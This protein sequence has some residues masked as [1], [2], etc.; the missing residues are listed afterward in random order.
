MTEPKQSAHSR[1]ED[2][3]I[4]NLILE[5][6]SG[7]NSG[8]TNLQN[9]VS[10]NYSS[11]NNTLINVSNQTN[12]NTTTL[13][14]HWDSSNPD[15]WEA[16]IQDLEL[17][18]GG[19][20]GG[21]GGIDPTDPSVRIVYEDFLHLS[22][23]D[24]TGTAVSPYLNGLMGGSL[25]SGLILNPS[26]VQ[27]EEADNEQDHPGI[28]RVVY[29][30]G[31]TLTLQWMSAFF[32]ID[33]AANVLNWEDVSRITVILKSPSYTIDDP[34][35]EGTVN[36]FLFGLS[37]NFLDP[38]NS[39]GVYFK[40]DLTNWYAVTRSGVNTTSQNIAP[41]ASNTWYRLDLKRTILGEVEF[42]INDTL[43]HTSTTNIP[44]SSLNLGLGLESSFLPGINSIRASCLLDFIGVKL[45]DPES[46]GILPTGTTVVGTANEVE[47]TY[48]GGTQV[49]TVGLPN[50][51][52][53]E[54]LNVDSIDFN[55]APVTL[56]ALARMQWDNDYKTVRLGMTSDINAP[57]SQALYKRVRNSSNTT[58][59]NLG[60]VLYING[61]QGATVLQV[62]L[63]DASSELTAATTIGIAAETI[64]ANGTGMII[65]QG[66]LTGLNTNAYS[67][68]D[69]VWL[70][71][72]AG[73]WTTTRPTAPD[74]G[75]FLGW[76][77]K[78][79]GAPD[80]SIYVK[81]A[82]GQE[83]YEL[84]DVKITSV[85]N[86]NILKWDS[87]DSR[88]ENVDGSKLFDLPQTRLV[89]RWASAGNGVLQ[90]VTI[91]SGIKLS[92][93][94]ILSTDGVTFETR[95]LNAGTGLTGGGDLSTDRT[96][97]VDFASS[98]TSS[99][100]KAVRADDSRLS[101]A[102]TPTAHTHVLADITDR[103]T[104]LVKPT[105]PVIL[106]DDFF[107]NTLTTGLIGELGWR[108][109]NGSVTE[110]AAAD[111]HPGIIRRT[112]AA[113]TGNVASTY[114][115]SA[116]TSALFRWDQFEECTFVIDMDSLASNYTARVGITNQAGTSPPGIGCYFEGVVTGGAGNWVPIVK[117]GAN[118]NSTANA[119]A[120]S[121]NW[122]KMKI[123]RI[124]NTQVGFTF[125]NN[126]EVTETLGSPN[127]IPDS[128]GMQWF[129]Q[130]TPA[131]N[132]ARSMDIDF[133]SGIIKAQTR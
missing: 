67:P 28:L 42:Y 133:F 114:V 116:V 105:N 78:S 82:N 16:R 132:T 79:A 70:S 54:N 96:L 102:R 95:L 80:G 85:A 31:D 83:L 57:V 15:G 126:S 44:T 73:A 118:Q 113:T 107:S 26:M 62:G 47:V 55:T 101:D 4:R 20:G 90:E 7:L 14:Y 121:T 39:D 32:G 50:E 91:G 115:G 106:V 109:T 75:V 53:V 63:A 97:S 129:L 51:V 23:G 112:S 128:T 37:T 64:A 99:S 48:D 125:D 10:S 13:N 58:A 33:E 110:I 52:T 60:E 27:F 103:Y 11:L 76:I 92:N 81:V 117:N 98:G 5:S 94:G 68:G 41:Y 86:N 93:T 89:G 29:E 65:L 9:T 130:L 2:R 100:T 46:G 87:A 18:G 24:L 45:G 21:G 72:T 22:N 59:I 25:T 127:N 56:N 1:R 77:V 74:H 120:V 35:N 40:S 3:R 49:Y 17:N 84:H 71:T 131:A 36:A 108:F 43:E 34:E 6:T 66:L 38:E 61:S 123:R 8:L 69:L 119:W 122:A 104:E 12:S 88:W 111:G 19:G 30:D 124:S